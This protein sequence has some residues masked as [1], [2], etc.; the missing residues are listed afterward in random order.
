MQNFVIHTTELT[1]SYKSRKA[2]DNVNLQINK[3]DIY[4]FLGPNGA[5]KTT[6]IRMLLGLIKP[7]Q[8]KI[9]VFGRDLRTDKLAILRK[10][11]SLVESPS[12]YGHLTARENLET[13]RRII[14]VPKSRIDEVLALVRLTGEA[15]R[16]VKG[17]SLGMKQRLGIATALL[18]NP[19]LL[20]LD[21]PTNGL[22]PTG[23]QEMRELIK[24][25]PDQHGITVLV[26][27]HLLS[28]ID[29]MATRVGIIQNGSMLFQDS[30]EVLR[31][32]AKSGIRIVASEP[33]KAIRT[34]ASVG[35]YAK[36][37]AQDNSLLIEQVSDDKVAR[38]IEYL[39]NAGHSVYRAEGIQSSLEDI[40]LDLIG[41]GKSL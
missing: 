10:V 34:I 8:G 1:K 24:S 21:E 17:F 14:D 37:N 16:P 25:L 22:D 20:I 26:S 2:V 31:N 18:G 6:T 33:D 35:C 12:Y 4:G 11:G 23:I 15:N 7:T 41:E 27:S 28:E 13:V 32:Q 39:V 3:G 29:Q 9:R 40:F 19:E 5:G 30:I 38:I 36:L